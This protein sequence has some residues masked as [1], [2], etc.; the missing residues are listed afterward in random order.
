MT[1][2]T[3]NLTVD[4]NAEKN[5]QEEVVNTTNTATTENAVNQ[6]VEET[7][8]EDSQSEELDLTDSIVNTTTEEVE[9]ETNKETD[10]A[11]FTKDELVNE[12]TQILSNG[13]VPG[14]RNDVENI[15]TCFYKIHNAEIEEKRKAFDEAQKDAEEKADFHYEPNETELKFKEL[16][17]EYRESKAAYNEKIEK[18]KDENLK[19]RYEIIE[20]IKSLINSNESLDQTFYDFRELQNKWR[21]VGPVPQNE[22]KIVWENYHYNVEKF[23]DYVKIN[24]ELRDLDLKKNLEIKIKLCEKAEELLLE[25]S[26][27]RAFK[28][29]QTFHSEWRE[30]GPVPKDKRDELWERFKETTTNINK[31]YQEHFQALKEEQENNLKEKTLL[32]QKAEEIADQENNQHKDWDEKSRE[33]IELQK[34]WKLIGFAPKKDNNTIYNRFRE[35]C[36]KFFGKKRD[37]YAQTK[38]E[39][40][41]NLQLKTELCIQAEGLKE[42]TEWKQSTEEYIALQRKWKTIGP[43]ARKHSEIIWKRFRAACN[44]FFDKKNEFFASLDKNQEENLTKKVELIERVENYKPDESNEINLEILKGFQKEFTDIGHVPFKEK[45]EIQ[46]RFRSAINN[47][48]DSIKMDMNKRNELKFKNHLEN[49][50]ASGGKLR[51]EK[52]RLSN[53]LKQVQNDII[54]LEN[55]IGFFNNSKNAEALLKDIKNKIKKSKQYADTLRDQIKMLRKAEQ[56]AREGKSVQKTTEPQE[57]KETNTANE[58][59]QNENQE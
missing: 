32:C 14:K 40:V 31:S 42:S 30:T 36:D 19:I 24:K 6:Q 27:V 35:A 53:K 57:N 5:S 51:S 1:E 43:V 33:L 11:E 13:Y 23:Y 16:I 39:Q 28:L 52:E 41:R 12:L 2:N 8:N 21:E 48:F 54:L 26:I 58:N 46:K 7:K 34:L 4:V 59:T 9:V 37:F 18:A 25:P 50:Q 49:I 10:F 15:K 45:D 17:K 22:L 29:L 55:N 44:F 20:N 56:E 38:A 47:Q 3:T